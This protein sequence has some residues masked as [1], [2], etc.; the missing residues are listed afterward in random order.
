MLQRL[1]AHPD[2][3]PRAR[4]LIKR[5][6]GSATSLMGTRGCMFTFHRAAPSAI[7]DRLPNRNFYLDL[8]FLDRLLSH[9]NQSGWK[10]VT[11]DEMQRQLADG[12]DRGRYVNFSVDD[13]YRDTYED[14]VPLFRRH[15]VPVTLFV[16][17]G[18]PDGTLSLWCAG[19][20][21][22]LLQRD[23]VWHGDEAIILSSPDSRRETYTR[24]ARE[25]DGP[26]AARHYTE[27]CL[28]NDIDEHAMHWKHAISWDMLHELRRDALVEIGAHTITHARISTCTPLAATVEL[29][30]SR[31]R[32][33]ERLGVV[34]KHFA[35]PYGR[36]G[37]CGERDFGLARQ[38][39]FLS[40]ATTRKGIVRKEQDAFSLPR[41]TLNGAH[42]SL[43]M[44]ELHLLGITGAA[45]RILGRV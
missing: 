20:E 39:G 42:R 21:D 3:I 18:I 26:D 44:A 23:R 13:C 34:P 30:G 35:F 11:I 17:T 8:G 32:L 40:A 38:A 14:V 12:G 4:R 7:W 24:L 19:L 16:T 6:A 41:N 37:D 5:L 27:F 45:A 36:S 2:A 10:I 15:G 28:R 22:A 9:L 33:R 29:A 1:S 31:E 25:W 43:A